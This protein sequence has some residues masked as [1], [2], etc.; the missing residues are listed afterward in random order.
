MN[1]K[2][3]VCLFCILW[4]VIPLLIIEISAASK[5]IERYYVTS[6]GIEDWCLLILAMTFFVFLNVCLIGTSI[7][8][9]LTFSSGK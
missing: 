8:L 4:V 6:V 1:R 5:M 3:A 2:Q 7:A 9:Y